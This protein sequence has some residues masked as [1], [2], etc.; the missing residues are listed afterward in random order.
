M[1]ELKW[2]RSFEELKIKLFKL[3]SIKFRPQNYNDYLEVSRIKNSPF[4]I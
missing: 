3:N 4:E 2:I 1:T